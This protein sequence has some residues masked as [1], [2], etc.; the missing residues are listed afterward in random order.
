[1]TEVDVMMEVIGLVNDGAIV[2]AQERVLEIETAP[3]GAPRL[4]SSVF[5]RVLR[6][7]LRAE[8]LTTDYEAFC[9]RSYGRHWPEVRD[10]A[11]A[12]SR[13][14]KAVRS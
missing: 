4:P 8:C 7:A 6:A 10:Q 5:E 13:P 2:R 11:R 3:I 12:S 14:P 9:R 1:M